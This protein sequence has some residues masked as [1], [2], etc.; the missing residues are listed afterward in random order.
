MTEETP[1]T[2][3]PAPKVSPASFLAEV[4][5]QA[6]ITTGLAV[7]AVVLAAAPYVVPQLQT[8][9]VQRG[10]MGKPA[11]VMTA[12][13]TY[14]QQKAEQATQDMVVQIKA[15]HDSI[16]NDKNDPVINPSGKIKLVEFL[17]YQ[18]AYCRAVTPALH[19][20]LDENPDVQL[21]VKEYPIIH[22]PMSIS[23]AQV[24]MAAY[25]GGHY[26]PIHYAFL[27]ETP[28]SDAEMD[29]LLIKAGLDPKAIRAAA[30]HK[31]IQDHVSR[32]VQLGQD[33]GIQGTPGFFVGNHF[34]DGAR[35]ED[36]KAAVDAVRA[37]K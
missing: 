11:M 4:F 27:H 17:D 9:Q 24:A 6:N 2:E 19:A 1:T 16:F 33:M 13:D 35:I 32:T 29:A 8:Y 28:K 22:P 14:Q 30:V 18:C 31:D 10:L 21:V 37:G 20:F 34:I 12:I 15:H 7:F 5:S 25:Q 23:M 26:E 36:V 3:N